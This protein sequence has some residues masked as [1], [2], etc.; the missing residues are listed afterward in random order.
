MIDCLVYLS[1]LFTEDFLNIQNSTKLTSLKNGYL[2]KYSSKKSFFMILYDYV[3]M[4][5]NFLKETERDV[6][7][8]FLPKLNY[9]INFSRFSAFC[10][11]FIIFR[12]LLNKYLFR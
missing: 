6:R 11:L 3:I 12:K 9:A 10:K 4:V 7:S 2:H 1:F 8:V 5:I